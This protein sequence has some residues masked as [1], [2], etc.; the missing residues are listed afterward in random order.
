MATKKKPL[1]EHEHIVLS[2]RIFD[3]C[4]GGGINCQ[5]YDNRYAEDSTRVFEFDQRI[6]IEGVCLWPNDREGSTYIITLYGDDRNTDFNVQLKDFRELDKHGA[7]KSRKR[8]DKYTPVYNPPDSIG[9]ID[10]VRGENFWF[11]AVWVPL[12]VSGSIQQ[13]LTSVSEVYIDIHECKL[14]RRRFVRSI[15]FSTNDPNEE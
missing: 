6:E 12:T 2:L 10:K 9:Y 3:I 5:I 14:G 1:I 13:L 7:P 8:G 4:V 15:H 11:T